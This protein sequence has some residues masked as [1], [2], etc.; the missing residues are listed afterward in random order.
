M[1]A[2]HTTGKLTH[3]ESRYKS[4]R[5]AIHANGNW[6]MGIQHNG[7]SLVEVQRE[8]MRRLAACW[9]ACD[10]S[11]TEWL[12]FQGSADRVDQCGQPEPFET[13]YTEAL[14]NGV[15]AMEQRDALLA[16]LK[17]LTSAMSKPAHDAERPNA[18]NQ[19]IAAMSLAS[20]NPSKA[21]V[22]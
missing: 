22:Q 13:R 5:F 6:L 15:K 2:S 4:N 14:K 9:N 8:N 16:A 19:A 1:T 3:T 21:G 10:G 12:E 20:M 17:R 7:E 11:S 18:L